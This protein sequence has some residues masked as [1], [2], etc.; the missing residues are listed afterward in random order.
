MC[1]ILLTSLLLY[2]LFSINAVAQIPCVRGFV[3]DP[4][5]N[6]VVDADLDFDD[7][8]TGQRIYTPNDNTDQDGFYMVCL[9]PG[10]YHVSYAPPPNSHLLGYQM[11]NVD[12]TS[13]ESIDTNIILNF[14]V[15]ISGYIRDSL[16]I[17]VVM[18]D[19]DADA[20]LTNQRIYTPNDNSIAP[21]GNYWVVVPPDLYR[22]RYQPP[23]DSRLL[24]VQMDSVEVYTDMSINII[25]NNGLLFSG[26]V[27]DES[28]FGIADV[29][30]DLRPVDTGEKIFLSNNSTDSVGAFSFASPSNTFQ[31][32]YIPP[33]GSRFVAEVVDSFLIIED[34]SRDQILHEGYLFNGT[35]RDSAGLPIQNID[36]DL[37]IENTG[38]KIFTPNDKSDSTG[39]VLFA[40]NPDIYTI[41]VVPPLGT[42][43]DRVVMEN[44]NIYSDTSFQFILPEVERINFSGSVRNNDSTGISGVQIDLISG[45]TGEKIFVADN[46]TDTLGVFNLAVPKGVFNLEFAPSPGEPYVGLQILDVLFENDTVS[47]E[48]VL[49]NGYIVTGNVYNTDGLPIEEIDFDFTDESNGVEIFTPNDDTDINGTAL[50]VVPSGTY[51]IKLTPA[52][53]QTFTPIV[54]N[55]I[56][57]SSDTTITFIIG[58]NNQNQ[59]NNIILNPNFPNP[60]NNTTSISFILLQNDYISLSIF[61]DLGQRVKLIPKEHYLTGYHLIEWDGTNNKNETVAS[62][63][64]FYKI[65]SSSTNKTRKMLFIK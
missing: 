51:T 19:F 18:A 20:I 30:I 41:R 11:F 2:F 60:F 58:S 48:I 24:G 22:L 36:F 33:I 13:G 6:P 17:G 57:I 62:G 27:L 34:I 52:I 39:T 31:L 47:S 61:N 50:M 42:I 64:Y 12:L 54:R 25:M 35:V 37:I 7:A 38:N 53:N 23:L 14:G 5:G 32:R 65:E 46:I 26:S 59:P 16:G 29:E 28:D 56:V 15:V 9:L 63:T 55:N 4:D 44:V 1:R 45:T 21:E 8:L 43:Y 40:L 10:I 3:F 49:E